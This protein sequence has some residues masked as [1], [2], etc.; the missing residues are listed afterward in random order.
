VPSV[1]SEPSV[2][3]PTPLPASRG[4][5]A[6][7][8]P[9][10]F[11][12]SGFA[13]LLDSKPAHDPEPPAQARRG[14]A[15]PHRLDDAAKVSRR[16]S[17]AQ[18]KP[19]S[20]AGD[21]TQ[22]P[23]DTTSKPE[24]ASPDVAQRASSDAAKE[25]SAVTPEPATQSNAD[26]ETVKDTGI[27]VDAAIL[28]D[29]TAD[30][31]APTV[32]A[33]PAA[34]GPSAA[35]IATTPTIAAAAA[36]P[37]AAPESTIED[38]PTAEPSATLPVQAPVPVPAPS[39][40]ATSTLGAAQPAPIEQ[41]AKAPA[42][43]ATP[44]AGPGKDAAPAQ[45]TNAA[46]PAGPI[47]QEGPQPRSDATAVSQHGGATER[48]PIASPQNAADP[49]A[50]S[51]DAADA[52]KAGADL[53]QNLGVAAP[54]SH[55]APAQSTAAANAAAAAAPTPAPATAVPV[56]GVAVE[57]ATQTL[58]GKNRFEIRLDPPELGRIDVRIDIDRDGHVSSRLVVERAETLD[59]LRRDAPQ[60]ERALQ[61][62]GLKTSDNALEFSLRDQA[63]Q[64]DDK[65]PHE[66]A[67]LVV[68]EDGAAASDTLQQNYGRRFGLGGGVDIRV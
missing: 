59:L 49:I 14:E 16:N 38:A 56:A 22:A 17:A 50:R 63:P 45:S 11:A 64:R 57:I 26:G 43:S 6:S 35:P 3:P 61:Q 8:E 60:L 53:V 40:G 20:P 48:A 18:T 9:G 23:A 65:N 25:T 24:A 46:Q 4:A 33:A 58:A 1:A 51:N 41:P 15:K 13:K 47:P 44:A 27:A 31:L 10:G 54:A 30:A 62:A 29:T 55:A 36:L 2:F 19:K 32:T 5:A 42:Q 37:H 34:A 39:T 28:F 67:R 7:Q 66:A 52:V 68:P 12:A 21:D